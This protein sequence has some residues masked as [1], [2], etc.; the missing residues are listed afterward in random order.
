MRLA[1][2]RWGSWVSVHPA[3]R[4]DR[5]PAMPILLLRMII[6]AGLK[7]PK[8]EKTKGVDSWRLPLLGHEVKSLQGTDRWMCQDG[9]KLGRSKPHASDCSRL[10]FFSPPTEMAKHWFL[11]RV[12]G[13]MVCSARVK[14]YAYKLE[15]VLPRN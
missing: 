15:G 11:T 13:V 7:K 5:V 14:W 8:N 3:A 4:T 2:Q 9:F 10:M 12:P 6:V 1:W